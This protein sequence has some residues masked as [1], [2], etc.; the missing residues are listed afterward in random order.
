MSAL[1]TVLAATLTRSRRLIMASVKSNAL[2]AWAFAND[3]VEYEDGGYNITNPLTVGRNPN[4]TSMEYYDTLPVAQT[5]EFTT[6][7]Y[8]WERLS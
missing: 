2:V 1:S 7:E 3:R 6:V 4:V 8:R 5:N